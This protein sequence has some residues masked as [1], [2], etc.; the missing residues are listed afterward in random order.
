[1]RVAIRSESAKSV[2]RL[3]NVTEN[4]VYQIKFRIKNLLRK[5]GINCLRRALR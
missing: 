1:M 3:F 5:H 4:H 2:S